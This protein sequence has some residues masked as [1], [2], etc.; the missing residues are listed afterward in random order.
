ML[1]DAGP[2]TALFDRSDHHHQRIVKFWRGLRVRP[3]TSWPVMA[4][5]CHLLN[6][7][8]NAQLDF[9]RW[10]DRGGVDVVDM[11]PGALKQIIHLTEKYHDRPMDLAD[12][13]LI[14]LAMQ[15]GIRHILTVDSDFDIY[16][17]PNKTHLTNLLQP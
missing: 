6:F 14:V 7:S 13:S 17:L 8:V 11:D 9:L 3:L 1:A 12:A 15:T 5:V 2:L 4:E 10:V 16:R